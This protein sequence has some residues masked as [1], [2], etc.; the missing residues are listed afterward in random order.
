MKRLLRCFILL[1]IYLLGAHDGFVALWQYGK[2][3][4]L[5][6]FP[7]PLA[8][9]PLSDQELLKKGIRIESDGELNRLLEDYFS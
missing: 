7:Y 5:E 4:P 8:S 2:P 6:V 1:F 3:Q 9:F